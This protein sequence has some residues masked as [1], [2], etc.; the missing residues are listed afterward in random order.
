MAD[1][2]KLPVRSGTFDRVISIAVIHHFSTDSLRI[3]A[4]EEIYRILRP[5]GQCLV[6]VW[7]YEQ[8]HKKFQQQDVFVKWNLQNSYTK[9]GGG[10]LED[11]QQSTEEKTSFI[12]TG[13][14]D[15]TRQSVVYHRYYHMFMKG[16]LEKLIE[17]NFKDRFAIR[18]NFFDHANWV[19]ICE[20]I[21]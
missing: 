15:D 21:G 10:K 1:S 12:E 18:D 19:V 5:G 4:L 3:Q 9:K 6:Y 11:S 2:L 14:R 13:Q 8:E 7:A 17:E 20:K 16:E